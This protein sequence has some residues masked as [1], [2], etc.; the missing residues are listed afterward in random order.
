ML[1]NPDI[2]PLW[3]FGVSIWALMIGLTIRFGLIAPVIAI[4][5]ANL[6]WQY[7]LTTDFSVWYA[8]WSWFLPLLLAALVAYGFWTAMAGRSLFSD[9]LLHD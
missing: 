5:M 4:T 9:R 7:P 1:Q 6:P 2:W 3:I 8:G